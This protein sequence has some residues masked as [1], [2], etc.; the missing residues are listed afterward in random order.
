M[1][2]KLRR[3]IYFTI[4]GGSERNDPTPDF[5]KTRGRLEYNLTPLCSE[6]LYVSTVDYFLPEELKFVRLYKIT[7]EKSNRRI[8]SELKSC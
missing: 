2:I 1:I 6:D 3:T 5:L 8:E 7:G 4:T